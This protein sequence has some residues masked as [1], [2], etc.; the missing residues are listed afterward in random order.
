ML[1]PIPLWLDCDTGHDDAFALL[2]AAHHP[3]LHLLGVSTTYGNA[4]LSNTT[5]NT[6][7]IL[8]AINREDVPVY[9]G[10]AKPFCRP[11]HAAV[12][13]HG[14]TGL[15]GTTCLPVPEVPIKDDMSAVEAMYRALILTPPQTAWLV[16][17]G[18]LTNSALLF[19]VHPDL[20]EHVAGVSLMGGALGGGFT[21]APM[22]KVQGQGDRFGNWTPWAEFNI[23]LDPESA[24]GIFQNEVL[25]RKT[26]VVPLDLSHQFLATADVQRGILYGFNPG[27]QPAGIT[28][29]ALD[30]AP[31]VRRLF[32]EILT[33][34]AKTY[35][36]VF[37]LV[38]GPPTHD[39]LAVA[40]I[41]APELFVDNGGERFSVNVVT[42][43]VHDTSDSARG[44]NSQCGK[45]VAQLLRKGQEV[46]YFTSGLAY[47]IESHNANVSATL[48]AMCVGE[49]WSSLAPFCAVLLINNR[50][51]LVLMFS[52]RKIQVLYANSWLA[53]MHHSTIK[54]IMTH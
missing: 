3:R 18:A 47:S 51:V 45:T 48:I 15:D 24:Q 32:F 14:E 9:A 10:V 23:W 11:V 30:H 54:Q 20:A 37:G 4:P 31:V 52:G 8:K 41:F 44:G 22:G 53:W 27:S 42:E 1:S 36:D 19:A 17:V 28:R 7:A 39:P 25:A 35:A 40:A 50:F 29:D 21:D 46:A 33:F 16:A 2:L 26:T 38:A 34:F 12:D 43:G 49:L 13:I 6:R 5:Y